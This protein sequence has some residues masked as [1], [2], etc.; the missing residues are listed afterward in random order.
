LEIVGEKNFLLVGNS[1]EK[2]FSVSWEKSGE[3]E[4]C[5]LETVGR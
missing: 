3:K 4:L 1:G 2:E 5:F